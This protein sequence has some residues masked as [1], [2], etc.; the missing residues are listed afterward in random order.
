MTQQNLEAQARDYYHHKKF[1]QN[2]VNSYIYDYFFYADSEEE[3]A[4]KLNRV[5]NIYQPDFL[6]DE[7]NNP[8]M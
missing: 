2:L 8:H 4:Q 3:I 6:K 1:A 5:I 7:G